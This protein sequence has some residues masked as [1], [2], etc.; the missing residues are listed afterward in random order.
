MS[1]TVISQ[2]FIGVLVNPIPQDDMEDVLEKL[3]NGEDGS[4]KCTYDGKLLYCDVNEKKQYY[5]REFAGDLFIVGEVRGGADRMDFIEKAKAAGYEV[6]QDTVQP[7]TCVW[8][9]GSDSPMSTLSMEKFLAG[10]AGA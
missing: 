7:Y 9:N 5:Q 3:Y 2:G 8:Y 10:E 6:I 4:L 1:T